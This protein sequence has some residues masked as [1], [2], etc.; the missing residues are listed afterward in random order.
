MLSVLY[1]IVLYFC[2]ISIDAD[3]QLKNFT[4]QKVLILRPANTVVINM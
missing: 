4:Y 2:W 3:T 1:N